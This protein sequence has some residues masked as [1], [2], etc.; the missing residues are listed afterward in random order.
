MRWLETLR[1]HLRGLLFRKR[2]KQRLDAEVG[3]HLDALIAENVAAGMPP[4]EA[5]YAAIRTF[6]NATM[7]NEQ[8]Q[9]TWGWTWVERLAQDV[10]FATRQFR[11][12]PG[13]ALIAI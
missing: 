12:A 13:F 7:V 1:L 11:R 2:E 8:A 5:R 10:R 4:D 6:G 3:F 9:E